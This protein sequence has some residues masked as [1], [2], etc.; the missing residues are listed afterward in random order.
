DEGLLA[1]G[2]RR[3]VRLNREHLAMVGAFFFH[4]YVACRRASAGVHRLL[5]RRFVVHDWKPVAA[6]LGDFGQF[7]LQDVPKDELMRGRKPGIK[8]NTRDDRLEGVDQQGTLAAAA[9]AL[10]AAPQAKVLTQM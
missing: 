6:V 3:D 7:R 4:R 10:L 8:K 1:L 5:Q 9:A 2:R